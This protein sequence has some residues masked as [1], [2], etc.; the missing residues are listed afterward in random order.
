[1]KR[2]KIGVDFDST[3]ATEDRFPDAGDIIE[4]AKETITK[5]YNM[6]HIIIINTMRENHHAIP[7][8]KFLKENNIPY[9]YFN[10]NH[11]EGEE[12]YGYDSRKMGC[13]IFIDDRSLYMKVFGVDWSKIDI[14]M[15]Y[16]LKTQYND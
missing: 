9:H 14:F 1:M 12:V 13:D 7:A 2:I 10:E 8:L 3:I 5:W 6:G 11:P 15:D 4:G 16:I